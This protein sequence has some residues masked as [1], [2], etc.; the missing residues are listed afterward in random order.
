MSLCDIPPQATHRLTRVSSAQPVPAAPE[1]Q[2]PLQP[3]AC[4]EGGV[5]SGEW[6]VEREE[7]GVGSRE[8]GGGR[9]EGGRGSGEGGGGRGKWGGRSGEGGVHSPVT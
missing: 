9:K 4:R 8:W 2:Q 5:G 6:G 3:P 7:G 1:E